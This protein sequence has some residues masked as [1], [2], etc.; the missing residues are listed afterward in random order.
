M[1]VQLNHTIVWCRD[2]S[3]SAKLLTEILGRPPATSFGL[4]MVVAVDNGA[5]LDFHDS[6]GEIAH[7]HYD[8][9][10]G[11]KD[12]DEIFARIRDRGLDYWADPGQTRPGK[13]NRRDGGRGLYF[14][15]PDG[16]L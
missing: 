4:S 14:E 15:D 6:V 7:Q 12:F 5:S 2:K 8:F 10:I 3:R 1:S 9:L 16:H 13:I 11:E